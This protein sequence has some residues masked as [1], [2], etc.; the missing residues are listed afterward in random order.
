MKIAK[1][2]RNSRWKIKH[3]FDACI[4]VLSFVGFAAVAGGAIYCFSHF[5]NLPR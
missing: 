1:T 5:L 3:F 4:A 2:D